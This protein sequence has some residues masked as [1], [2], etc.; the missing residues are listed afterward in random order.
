[1][2]VDDSFC[3]SVGRWVSS[4]GRWVEPSCS[5]SRGSN[6][7]LWVWQHPLVRRGNG[8]E[9]LAC[10]TCICGLRRLACTCAVHTA[11]AVPLPVCAPLLPRLHPSLLL[12]FTLR[13]FHPSAALPCPTPRFA[14]PHLPRLHISRASPSPAP[15]RLPR[16]R[17]AT[18][19]HATP[20]RAAPRLA[21]Q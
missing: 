9:H 2:H 10:A 15:P 6:A 14:S 19:R 20:R 17:L 16:L 8:K 11:P 18:P 3:S 4:V 1:M 7:R 12:R 21:A 13:Q 5:C